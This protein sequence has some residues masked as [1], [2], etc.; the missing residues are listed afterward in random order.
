MKRG[1][2]QTENNAQNDNINN[3]LNINRLNFSIKRYKE[4]VKINVFFLFL[5]SYLFRQL[6]TVYRRL[7]LDLLTHVDLT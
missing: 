4:A 2:R 5:D 7:I 3:N 6:C 1:T